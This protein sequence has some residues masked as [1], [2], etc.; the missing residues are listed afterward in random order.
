[1]FWPRKS[2]LL[3]ILLLPL[4]AALAAQD[5]PLTKEQRLAA[6]LQKLEQ[7]KEEATLKRLASNVQ[8]LREMQ[9]TWQMMDYIAPDLTDE[10][11]QSAGFVIVAGEFLSIEVHMGHFDEDGFEVSS[12]IQTGTYR[13]NF[14]AFSELMATCLIGSIDDGSGMTV[15]QYPGNISVYAIKLAGNVMQFLAE[16]G[17][18]MTLER[19]GTG[20][21]TDLVYEEIDW[22]PGAK[23]REAKLAAEAA[24]QKEPLEGDE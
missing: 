10:G 20:R 13:L 22:L 21:L 18:K 1:M 3:P 11:K 15:P 4:V 7:A 17:A 23:T 6:Q 8:T 9:G 16:D 5:V 2:L 12:F 14:N 24:A 19:V